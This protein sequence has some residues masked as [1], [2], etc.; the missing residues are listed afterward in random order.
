MNTDE[1]FPNYTLYKFPVTKGFGGRPLPRGT[2]R[3]L[4]QKAVVA[5]SEDEGRYAVAVK[6]SDNGGAYFL[7]PEKA[8]DGS[9][10]IYV[11]G[12]DGARTLSETLSLFPSKEAA[13]AA[14][15]RRFVH[16]DLFE[17]IEIWQVHLDHA[18]RV[19]ELNPVAT[20]TQLPQ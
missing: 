2:V 7:T 1:T 3:G 19:A 5:A 20:L 4:L 15:D 6:F 9:L 10:K 8:H 13:I 16:N 12:V 18:G 17:H 11:N 14:I